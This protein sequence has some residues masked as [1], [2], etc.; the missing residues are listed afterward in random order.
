MEDGCRVCTRCGQL[1]SADEFGT[2]G[3]TRKGTPVYRSACKAC[4]KIRQ[5]QRRRAEAAASFDLHCY[6][7]KDKIARV[8]PTT[9]R[10]FDM[11][12]LCEYCKAKGTP[13]A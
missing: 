10:S 1:K 5:E 6:R 13:P 7:C 8:T 2:N 11:T 12:A 4:E 3:K 9:E